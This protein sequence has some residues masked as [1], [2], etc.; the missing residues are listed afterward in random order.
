MIRWPKVRTVAAFEFLSTVKRPGYLVVTFGMPLFLAAYAGIVGLPAYY[1]AQTRP[2]TQVYGVV[3]AAGVLALDGDTPAPNDSAEDDEAG[4]I[5]AAAAPQAAALLEPSPRVFRPFADEASARRALMD[6]AIKGYFVVPADYVERG[7]V[8]QYAPDRVNL[9]RG[10]ARSALAALIR[11]RLVAD[12]LA[13]PGAA[14]AVRPIAQTRHL[15]VT[16]DGTVKTEGEAA[17][18]V[19]VVVPVVFTILFL[20]SVLVTSGYLLQGTAVEKE[21]KVVDVLMASAS[22]DEILAGKLAGLSAAGVLQIAA[23]L[24]ILSATGIGIVPLMFATEFTIPWRALA[25]AL[26]LFLVAF[27]FFGSLMIG[28]GSLGSNMRESQQLAM[29]WSLTAALPLMLLG[30]LLNAPH[31]M[32]ARVMTWIPFTAGPVV[33]MR[34]ALDPAFLAWWEVAGPIAVLLGATWLA[35]RVG[36]RLFRIGLLSAGSRPSLA[37]VLR[38]ARLQ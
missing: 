37:E 14:R 23:W 28:T 8:D 5:A 36:A 16:S 4:E 30:V 10:G 15:V 17:S 20:M 6:D 33:V 38:Q 34:A 3:D 21:N 12:H 7:A 35:I 13:A 22:P 1:A 2:E 18:A 24:A 11:Q 25:L 32:A 31:G 29:V 27:L 19:R 9:S 26:P